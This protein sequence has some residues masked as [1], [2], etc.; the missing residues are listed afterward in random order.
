M[1]KEAAPAA[2]HVAVIGLGYIGLPTAAVLAAGGADVTGMDVNPR[3]IDFVNR[4]EVPF[5]EPDLGTVLAGAVS[6][7]RLRA[8]SEVPA[9]DAYIVAVP[10]PFAEN[11]NP[12]LSY[13]SAA[14]ESIAPQLTGGELVILE[15]TSPPGATEHMADVILEARSDLTLEPNKPNTVYLSLIHI[16]EP[17]RRPG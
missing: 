8:S 17:T 16:S 1:T 3:T 5:V 9:A 11:H 15:S 13:I 6:Q 12:D 10:T 4:G 14:A 2:P 7:G